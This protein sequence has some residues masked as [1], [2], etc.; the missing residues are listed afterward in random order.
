MY[1]PVTITTSLSSC[2]QEREGCRMRSCSP[3]CCAQIS[4]CRF[5]LAVVTTTVVRLTCL[6]VIKRSSAKYKIQYIWWEEHT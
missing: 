1:Q 6:Q 4:S 5:V 3:E 2:P